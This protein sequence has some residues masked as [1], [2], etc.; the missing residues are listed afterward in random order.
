MPCSVNGH[1]HNCFYCDT[2]PTSRPNIAASL[3]LGQNL[4]YLLPLLLALRSTVL[5]A[6]ALDKQARANKRLQDSHEIILFPFK[7]VIRALDSG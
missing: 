6:G 2:P 1:I 7:S 5:R 3:A 4:L